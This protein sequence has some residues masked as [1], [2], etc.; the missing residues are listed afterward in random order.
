VS[1]TEDVRH[2]LVERPPRKTCCQAAFLSGLLRQAGSLQVR[3]GG[4]L[5]VV[6]ELGDAGAARLTYA[7]LRARKAECEILSYREARFQRHGRV[8]LR[9]YGPHSLQ[10]L[11][12]VGVLSASLAPMSEPPRRV[13][14]RSCCR[15]AFLRGTFVAGGAVAAP[16][17]PAHLEL[18]TPDLDAARLLCRVAAQDELELHAVERRG[19][20]IA[21]AKRRETVHDLLVHIGCQNAVLSL[22]EAEV[23]ARTV[24]RANRLT[25]CDRANL[26]RSSAAAHRQREAI[27][28]LDLAAVS[29]PLREV[30]ELRLANPECSL[31]EL[32]ERASPP[33]PRS[34]VARRM[35]ALVSLTDP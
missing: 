21:Y 12:E 9:L 1:F 13:L 29:D 26:G 23:V 35:R 6:A 31:A 14:A 34:T 4:E 19:H 15:G 7:M 20:A 22:D 16:R 2:E 30:A 8:V 17:R 25:N 27:A 3:S 11:H 33:L 32:G 18:R 10:L 28:Q 5:A 24:E